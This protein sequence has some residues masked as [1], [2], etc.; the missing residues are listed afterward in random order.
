VRMDDGVELVLADIP[1]L[2]EG[3]S[4]GKGLGHRFLRHIERARVLLVLLDLAA[5]APPP[6]H[7]LD[8]L[9]HELGE[10]RPDL[11]DR[12]RVV[13]GSRA[14]IAAADP[15]DLLA[16]LAA[17]LGEDDIPLVVSAVTRSGLGPVLG[18]LAVAVTAARE[19]AAEGA[20]DPFVIH[21]PEPVGLRIARE[22]D[23]TF[24]V[25]GRPAERAVALNDLTNLE[26][27]EY[28][29]TRLRKLGVDKA[30]ARAGAQAGDAVRI[31]RFEFEY[32]E[33][34]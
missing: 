4:E 27:L 32:Q 31:G 18:R 9:L 19:A 1:G 14:D 17:R 24:V 29:Q 3:A 26:A 22:D 12:P 34:E 21:R 5:G 6:E 20:E 10:Y 8:V 33:D 28:V 16:P 23:G 15:A 25:L 30:L 7:Q 13:V 2:I 11:L